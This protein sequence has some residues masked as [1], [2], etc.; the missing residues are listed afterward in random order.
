MTF[1]L[2]LVVAV[3]ALVGPLVACFDSVVSWAPLLVGIILFETGN[4]DSILV[5]VLCVTVEKFFFISEN[6][7]C[8]SDDEACFAV[9][10]LLFVISNEDCL[11]IALD[12]QNVGEART[13]FVD[14]T[15]LLY[16]TFIVVKENP[17]AVGSTKL[18]TRVVCPTT[19]LDE[20]RECM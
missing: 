9:E 10:K 20:P 19:V 12:V 11:F 4:E 5:D 17:V 2:S 7:E 16:L 15:D 8:V 3:V 6:N 14:V 13:R 1:T 18:V